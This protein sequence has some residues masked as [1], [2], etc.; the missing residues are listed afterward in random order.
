[1]ASLDVESVAYSC[2]KETCSS[3]FSANTWISCFTDGSFFSNRRKCT[4]GWCFVVF[5]SKFTF[6]EI[7][8][9]QPSP[10][11]DAY[12]PVAT[13]ATD[14]LFVGASH[15]SNNTAELS[16][17]VE[18]CFWALS[19][20]SSDNFDRS[21]GF[22]I[23]SDS[24]YV[25]GLVNGKFVP[26]ENMHISL[27]AVHLVRQVRLLAAVEVVWIKAHAG[28]H[29]NERADRGAKLGATPSQSESSWKRNLLFSEWGEAEFISL[30]QT[31]TGV[32][33]MSASVKPADGN[34][35]HG[36]DEI[37]R[38]QSNG[39]P[40]PSLHMVTRTLAEV[41]RS[42]GNPRPKKRS[43]LPDNDEHVLNLRRLE[44]LRRDETCG[45]WGRRSDGD[46]HIRS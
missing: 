6:D 2:L 42:C 22:R 18:W 39:K 11:L 30:L 40:V 5:P 24:S 27:L 31:L 16:A 45:R 14:R 41:A 43:R 34:F 10:M 36:A 4:A 32:T 1:M 19:F 20:A 46:G 17:I 13:Q 28:F 29:G 33:R 21:L 23:Y 26:K 44:Q 9:G 38:E 15:L 37:R 7:Q 3:N 8:V 12:G 35:F 25:V